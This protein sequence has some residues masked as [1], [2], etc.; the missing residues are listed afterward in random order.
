[1]SLL[2]DLP[3]VETRVIESVGTAG[4][5]AVISMSLLVRRSALLA[6]GYRS[7]ISNIKTSYWTVY[8]II[9]Y[10]SLPG[11]PSII[12]RRNRCRCK[13]F[14][15]SLYFYSYIYF[16][17]VVCLSVVCLSVCHN[18]ALCLNSLT[19][20]RWHLAGTL[21]E[22]NDTLCQMGVRDPQG[23]NYLRV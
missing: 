13:L 11:R 22:P 23:E 10:T 1:M 20:L 3:A 12:I 18:R 4:S 19:R 9:W 6:V 8:S 15:L 2:V 14:R 7:S 16:G 5:C 21:A 17:S